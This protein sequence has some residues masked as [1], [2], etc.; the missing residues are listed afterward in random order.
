MYFSDKPTIDAEFPVIQRDMIAIDRELAEES[1][2]ADNY[3]LLIIHKLYCFSDFMSKAQKSDSYPLLNKNHVHFELY[4]KIF[5]FL[6]C[7]GFTSL[8]E[9]EMYTVL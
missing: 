9:K 7:I 1:Y 2:I 4:E 8:L 5:C 6:V 3:V